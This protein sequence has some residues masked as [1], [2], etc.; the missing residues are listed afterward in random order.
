[1]R[2]APSGAS[3]LHPHGIIVIG[4]V[5]GW[6]SDISVFMGGVI[7]GKRGEIRDRVSREI[8]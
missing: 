3:F 2:G 4:K 1:M 8:G 5:A 6:H 7:N